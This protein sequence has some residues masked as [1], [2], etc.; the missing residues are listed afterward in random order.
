M[1]DDKTAKP[2]LLDLLNKRIETKARRTFTH[3]FCLDP[4]AYQAWD[5]A[6]GE[7]ERLTPDDDDEGPKPRMAGSP[8]QAAKKQAVALEKTVLAASVWARFD[9]LTVAQRGLLTMKRE[10]THEEQ[11]DAIARDVVKA[12]F[13]RWLDADGGPVPELSAD[14][15]ARMIDSGVLEQTEY[16]VAAKQLSDWAVWEAPDLPKSLKR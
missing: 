3:P 9:A 7:V 16:M 14:D 8:L 5:E 15:F 13:V 4:E 2:S 11:T 6:R 1:T 10:G 12:A